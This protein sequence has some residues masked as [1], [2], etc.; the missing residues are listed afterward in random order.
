[1][2]RNGYLLDFWCLGVLLYLAVYLA[3]T[4]VA[5]PEATLET[6]LIRGLGTAGFVLLTFIL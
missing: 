4:L 5:R 2:K 3:V 6:A 1:M